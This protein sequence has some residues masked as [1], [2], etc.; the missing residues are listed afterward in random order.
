VLRQF[1]T[2]S[3]GETVARVFQLLAFF[4]LARVLGKTG[5]GEFG[6][7]VTIATYLVLL[8][9][10]GLDVPAIRDVAKAPERASKYLSITL[11]LRLVAATV[12]SLG[13]VAFAN[14][15]LLIAVAPGMLFGAALNTRWY[16]QAIHKS[17]VAAVA[18]VIPTFILLVGALLIWKSPLLGPSHDDRLRVA[19][20]AHGWGEFA[21]GAFL[22]AAVWPVGI[23][24]SGRWDFTLSKEAWPVFIS[25]LLGNL[26]YNFD[27]L[28]LGWMQKP[29]EAGLYLAAYRFING[30]SP[31]LV[32]LQ[33]S[34]L[35]LVSKMYPD[36]ARMREAAWGLVLHSTWITV[37]IALFMAI[38]ASVIMRVVYGAEYREGHAVLSVL[39]WALPIQAARSIW[40]QVLFAIHRQRADTR[41]LAI[42]AASNIVLDVLLIPSLGAM[43][44]AISTLIAESTLLGLTVWSARE[45]DG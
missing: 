21:A 15:P 14:Q 39:A 34:A 12:L 28:A 43:G 4:V 33:N 31:F 8:V 30:F 22:L 17:R 13:V 27:V 10:Q 24:F 6:Y 23:S 19:G 44:C 7:A 2:L 18:A 45:S 32:A 9:Q 11:R 40:R 35:P 25:L 20:Y 3:A 36:L 16:F 41:N 29:A 5:F 37:G 42:G 38:F 1:L 26:L